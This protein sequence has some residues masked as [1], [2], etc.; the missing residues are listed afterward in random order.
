M[1]FRIKEDDDVD[2]NLLSTIID[3]IVI[4]KKDVKSFWL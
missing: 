2:Y 3:Y 4:F 1:I